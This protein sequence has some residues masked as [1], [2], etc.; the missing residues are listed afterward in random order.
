MSVDSLSVPI[1]D[2]VELR[3][4]TSLLE[5]PGNSNI[6]WVLLGGMTVGLLIVGVKGATDPCGPLSYG[7][8]AC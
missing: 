4:V 2:I 7:S 1:A 8:W 5:T 6:G 3:D